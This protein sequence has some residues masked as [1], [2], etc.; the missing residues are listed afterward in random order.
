[1]NSAVIITILLVAL[2]ILSWL[3]RPR[4]QAERGAL[5][6]LMAYALMGGWALWFSFFAPDQEPPEFGFWKPTIM[7]W[8]LATIVFISPWLGWGLPVKAIFGDYFALSPRLWRFMNRTFAILYALLGGINLYTAFNNSTGDWTG[9]KYGLM[10]NL[11]IIILFRI[12]F[13][14]LPILL[15]VSVHLYQRGRIIYRY[16]AGLI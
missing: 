1:M 15:D 7:Y 4:V 10:M 6:L 5:L 13:V 8:S 14:W 3:W 16:L 2:L 11:L 9:L 12:N